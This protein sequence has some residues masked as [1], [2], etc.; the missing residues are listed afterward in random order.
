MNTI[1]ENSNGPAGKL[2][3]LG[4]PTIPYVVAIKQGEI[5]QLPFTPENLPNAHRTLRSSHTVVFSP[6][7]DF[8]K[9]QKAQAV[10]EL[11]RQVNEML[12]DLALVLK[13]GGTCMLMIP[14]DYPEWQDL[15]KSPIAHLIPG[16]R[17]SHEPKWMEI[18]SGPEELLN[19]TDGYRSSLAFHIHSAPYFAP[20][21]GVDPYDA[22]VDQII[23]DRR[24][25]A[26]II[27]HAIGQGRLYVIP[28]QYWNGVLRLLGLESTSAGVAGVA[29]VNPGLTRNLTNDALRHML[30]DEPSIV[31][32]W[33]RHL[34][35]RTSAPGVRSLEEL[36]TFVE[37]LERL[38]DPPKSG[39][40]LQAEGLDRP[41]SPESVRKL[42]QRRRKLIEGYPPKLRSLIIEIDGRL[43]RAILQSS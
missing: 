41:I 33:N 27:V 10:S 3:I 43:K 22:A 26:R 18:L 24:G 1:D 34:K 39:I 23:V 8:Y 36:V 29:R 38:P 16:M 40:Q 25:H 37:H 13:S 4:G 42:L 14:E 32:D 15:E 31:A 17:V 12:S 30:P 35:W 21:M 6:D 5:I 7:Q 9:N 19:L 11:T 2:L 20:T 28:M